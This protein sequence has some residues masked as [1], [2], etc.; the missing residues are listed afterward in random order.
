MKS[1]LKYTDET[2]KSLGIAGMAISMVACDAREFV[3]G[4]SMEPDEMQIE[5]SE[6]FFFHSNPRFSAKLAW[7]ESLRHFQITAGMIIANV[8]CREYAAGHRPSDE[9]LSQVRRYIDSEAESCSLEPDETESLYNKSYNYYT[10]LFSHPTVMYV[11]RD[12][13]TTLRMQR[14]MSGAEIMQS[15]ISLESL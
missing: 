14:R 3:V 4:V 9:R 10:R 13:A 8:L 15:L 1:S 5:L 7:K 11:A 6:D 2:D 12:F